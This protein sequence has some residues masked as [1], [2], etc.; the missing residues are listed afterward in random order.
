MKRKTPKK[1]DIL[2]V[3]YDDHGSAAGWADDKDIS[4]LSPSLTISSVGWVLKENKKEL[5]LKNM[6]EFTIGSSHSRV[7]IVKSAITRR[8]KIKCP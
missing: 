4:L 2:Y 7:Y 3:E 8:V 1:P 5:I 6:C